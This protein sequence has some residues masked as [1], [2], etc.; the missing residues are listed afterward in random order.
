MFALY[1]FVCF[2]QFL[3]ELYKFCKQCGVP[4][5][6]EIFFVC[7][8][9]LLVCL[10]A[11]THSALHLYACVTLVCQVQAGS[12]CLF[13]HAHG[14]ICTFVCVGVSFHLFFSLTDKRSLYYELSPLCVFKCFLKCLPMRMHIHNDCICLAFLHCV[15]SN[16]STNGVF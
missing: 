13:Q 14:C 6:Q 11:S 9:H 10:L 3:F 8:L 12:V 5:S 15:L 2:L 1:L 16:A 7:L 4:M